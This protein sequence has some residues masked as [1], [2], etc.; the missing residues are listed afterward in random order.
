MKS[1]ESSSTLT[2]PSLF[3][4]S[5]E[6]ILLILELSEDDDVDDDESLDCCGGGGGGIPPCAPA[7]APPCCGSG[8]FIFLSAAISSDV[9]K[10]PSL[11]VSSLLNKSVVDELLL[12]VELLLFTVV[13]LLF[14]P[15]NACTAVLNSVL[16][17]PPLLLVSIEVNSFCAISSKFGFAIC[18]DDEAPE[19]P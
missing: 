13:L 1:A 7:C 4:S 18:E 19:E 8:G 5:A 10:L 2:L 3:V 6:K 12:V 14:E 9:L 17:I 11:F 16:S 15:D